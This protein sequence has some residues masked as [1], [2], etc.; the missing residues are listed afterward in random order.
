MYNIN[1]I[2]LLLIIIKRQN[3]Q[4]NERLTIIVAID[5]M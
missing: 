4:R 1:F 2:V 5:F 3:K